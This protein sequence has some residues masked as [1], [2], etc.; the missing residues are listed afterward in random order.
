MEINIIFV[1]LNGVNLEGVNLCGIIIGL[2]VCLIINYIGCV[3]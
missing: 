3:L 2:S 1:N